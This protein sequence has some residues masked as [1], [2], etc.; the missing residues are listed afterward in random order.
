[1]NKED[2]FPNPDLV[3][4]YKGDNDILKEKGDTEYERGKYY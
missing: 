4:T 3:I 1:M 2:I